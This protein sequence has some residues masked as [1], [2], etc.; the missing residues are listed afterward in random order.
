MSAP[1][2]AVQASYMKNL[3]VALEAMGRLAEVEAADPVLVREVAAARRLAWL[4]VALNVRTVEAVAASLGEER[5]IALLAECVYHQFDTPLW[6][7]FVG[8]ALRLLGT[9]PGALGRWLPE[10]FA[11]I[12]RD[13]GRFSVERSGDCELTL[14]VRDLPQPLAAHGLWLRSLAGGMTPLFTLC[15]VGG[16]SVLAEVNVPAGW[17][18]YVLSWKDVQA[19]T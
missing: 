1:S 6:R 12:F 15:D 2:P 16:S 8:G 11:L 14:F 13:C 17:A 7:G 10:A 19:P 4:P 9:D 5:G 3:F 18:R